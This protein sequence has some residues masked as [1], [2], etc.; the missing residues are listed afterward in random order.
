MIRKGSA[1]SFDQGCLV[2]AI[3]TH[4]VSNRSHLWIERVPSEENISDPPSR[5]DYRLMRKL[6]IGWCQPVLSELYL[7]CM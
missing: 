6:G 7:E 4:A 1:K 2:N 5:E 3:W